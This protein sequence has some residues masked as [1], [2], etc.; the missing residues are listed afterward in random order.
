MFYKR[1]FN[2]NSSNAYTGSTSNLLRRVRKKHSQMWADLHKSAPKEKLSLI[3]SS[4]SMLAEDLLFLDGHMNDGIRHFFRDWIPK[5]EASLSH[6]MIMK[7]LLDL[8]DIIGKLVQEDI[9]QNI[10]HSEIV[11]F[12]LNTW[13]SVGNMNDFSLN[14]HML[15]KQSDIKVYIVEVKQSNRSVQFV[16]K[17]SILNLSLSYDT[18]GKINSI[19][20]SNYFDII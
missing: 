15:H 6:E 20:T 10:H 19:N 2:Y 5:A 14:L 16:A 1:I 9:K 17:D 4:A 7:A 18:K 13:K 12:S 3:S 8:H 11:V